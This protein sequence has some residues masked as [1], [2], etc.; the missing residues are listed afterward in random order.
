MFGLLIV[1]GFGLRFGYGVARYRG[2]LMRLSGNSFIGLWDHDALEHILISRAILSGKGYIV[3]DSP[4]EPGKHIRYPG[5]EALF[6]APL[7]EFFL[8]G[9]FALSGFS[10]RLF[11]PVQALLGGLSAGLVSLI[12]LQVF[13][14]WR[15]AW[16][17][18]A[19]AAVDP[20]LVNAAS[21]P[22]SETLFVFFFL[23]SIWAFLKWFQTSRLPWALL[24]GTT[25]GLCMLVRENGLLLVV[26]MGVA[27][28][29]VRPPRFRTWSGYA[30]IGLATIAVVAPWTIRNYVRFG[31]FVPVSSIVG[32]DFTEGNNECVAAESLF[33]PYWAEGPC[34][35][36]ARE[37]RMLL[38][39]AS[40][41][42]RVPEAVRM[43]RVCRRI[44]LQFVK[45]HPVAY[46]K[47]ALRRFWTTLLPFD[48]RGDQRLPERLALALY[49]L[50]VFPAGIVGMVLTVRRPEPARALLAVLVILDLASIVAVLY[51]SDLRFRIGIDL[52]LA[53]FAAWAYDE[54]VGPRA[55][56][57][58]SQEV[59]GA[60]GIGVPTFHSP[61][62][63]SP[64]PSSEND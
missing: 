11:F 14:R 48:P 13:G 4:P 40:F 51:W 39:T 54:W 57:L 35:P 5:Q 34:E 64:Q 29:L 63:A 12:A 2:K 52:L 15:A 6:K 44:A 20:L 53:C 1:L 7:Y 49:W 61:V 24:C 59:G 47:L 18:G 16:L 17:A 58:V 43:D 27:L 50:I 36:V 62:R 42:P 26:A 46:A 10:F 31:V 60:G 45:D 23:L 41:D 56:I 37:R 55:Q 32:V 3:D 19:A 38:A 28:L 33:E 9:T 21:Q 30:V 22:Y 8:A 25:V